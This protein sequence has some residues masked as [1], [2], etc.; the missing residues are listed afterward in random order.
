MPTPNLYKRISLRYYRYRWYYLGMV[1]IGVFVCMLSILVSIKLQI[2]LFPL[3]GVG[4][5]LIIWG[6]GIFLIIHWYGQQ[7]KFSLKLS[8]NLVAIREWGSAIFLNTW[9]LAG[10]IGVLCFIWNSV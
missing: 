1:G 10:S 2:N 5:L 3:L 6:W 7:S 4:W 9:F 8:K